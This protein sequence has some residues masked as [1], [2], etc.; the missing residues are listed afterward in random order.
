M[1]FVMSSACPHIRARCFPHAHS[2]MDVTVLLGWNPCLLETP[3]SPSAWGP[4]GSPPLP[5]Q[6]DT[7]PL[8]L[9]FLFP[10]LSP[11]AGAQGPSSQYSL[12][13][14][15]LPSSLAFL[16]CPQTG[17]LF[18]NLVVKP[19][20]VSSSFAQ[21]KLFPKSRIWKLQS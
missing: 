7:G 6:R 14:A 12:M 16:L 18:P 1:W 17:N 10:S 13:S 4:S 3:H 8:W 19:H 2:G 11:R 5:E 20:T 15:P 9:P 21:A